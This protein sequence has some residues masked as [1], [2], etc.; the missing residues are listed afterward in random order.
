[1]SKDKECPKFVKFRYK[2][3]TM[4]HQQMRLSTVYKRKWRP[5]KK[6]ITVLAKYLDKQGYVEL[7]KPF[8]NRA[9]DEA[10]EMFRKKR[11]K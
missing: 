6:N 2:L 11:K 4:I 3:V 9:I 8:R 10:T 7:E 5:T 1:M